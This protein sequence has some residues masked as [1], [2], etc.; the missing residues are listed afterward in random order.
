MNIDFS[1]TYKV[2]ER[3]VLEP[4]SGD[5]LQLSEFNGR[6]DAL[7]IPP[8]LQVCRIHFTNH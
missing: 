8:P 5:E 4:L 3:E 7:P 2:V 1:L 6:P